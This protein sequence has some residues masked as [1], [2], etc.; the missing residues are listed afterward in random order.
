MSILKKRVYVKELLVVLL[1]SILYVFGTLIMSGT[2]FSGYHLQDDHEIIRWGLS[3]RISESSLA[4]TLFAGFPWIGQRFRPLYL[5]VRRLRIFLFGDNFLAWSITIGCEIVVCIIVAYYVAKLWKCNMIISMMF[6]LLIITG[7]QSAI[8]WRLGPQEPMG[9]LL[10]MIS[11]LLILRYQI[12]KGIGWLIAYGV[13]ALL[14]SWSKESFTLILPMIPLIG[15]SYDVVFLTKEKSVFRAILQSIKK[16]LWAVVL[17]ACI[18]LWNMYLIIF[19]VGLLSTGY[20]GI[21]V[22]YSIK[23]YICAIIRMATFLKEYFVGILVVLIIY[24]FFFALNNREKSR[25]IVNKNFLLRLLPV[26]IIALGAIG[27]QLILHAKGGMWERYLVPMTTPWSILCVIVVYL[28]IRENKKLVFAQAIVLSILLCYFWGAKVFPAGRVFAVLGNE[29]EECFDTISN[30]ADED[31]I[32]IS[33]F[34]EELNCAVETYLGMK[35]Q[36]QF[37]YAYMDTTGVTRHYNT[38]EDEVFPSDIYDTDYIVCSNDREVEGF[39]IINRWGF[40][41]LLKKE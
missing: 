3:Y 22:T 19:K 41:K 23:D 28:I 39:E 18:F 2:L 12:N 17:C 10:L 26:I 30:C 6:A 40:G 14:C 20:A 11:I 4:D 31:E 9:L 13:T 5:L 38:K 16:N 36:Y 35:L 33:A 21:D 25:S 15:I 37:V 24:F 8:W 7:D 27:L 1:I 34:D 32:I 29:I